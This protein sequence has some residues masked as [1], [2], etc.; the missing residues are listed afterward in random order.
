MGKNRASIVLMIGRGARSPLFPYTTL[1]RSGD[2]AKAFE[3]PNT[4]MQTFPPELINFDDS[5][6]E[7]IGKILPYANMNKE[8]FLKYYTE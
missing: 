6:W 1:V 3:F 7:T 5:V 2:G 8:G 4:S